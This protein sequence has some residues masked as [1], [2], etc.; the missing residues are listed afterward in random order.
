MPITPKETVLTG[1]LAQPMT[2]DGPRIEGTYFIEDEAHGILHVPK[3]LLAKAVSL[4]G[5]KV[6]ATVIHGHTMS[7]IEAVVADSENENV[8]PFNS[9]PNAP[10]SLVEISKRA[11]H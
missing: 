10:G 8:I 11:S 2:K 1:R 6:R 3:N 7:R 9:A 4:F 5:K